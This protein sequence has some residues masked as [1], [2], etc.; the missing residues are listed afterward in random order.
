M[1]SDRA[2]ALVGR[3]RVLLIGFGVWLAASGGA[4]AS[5]IVYKPIDPSFGGDPLNSAQLLGVANAQN[6]YSPPPTPG[7]G[8]TSIAD[9]FAQQLQSRLLSALADDITK[10][11]FG[12]NPQQS[13]TIVFGD[14]TV[15][16][17]RDLDSVELDII[18]STTGETTKISVPL[19]VNGP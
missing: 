14:Q 9:Q 19:L 15:T 2:L 1:F 12:D 3:F 10:A 17:N 6:N 5:G 7:S 11:I 8:P 13:G 4:H 16:F 18:N